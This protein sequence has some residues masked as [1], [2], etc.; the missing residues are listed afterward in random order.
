MDYLRSISP[1]IVMVSGA[2]DA[3]YSS[4]SNSPPT[5]QTLNVEGFRI[6]LINGYQLIPWNDANILSIHARA[7]SLGNLSIPSNC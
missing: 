1:D 3:L 6:G 5:L 4:S 2:N 7:H